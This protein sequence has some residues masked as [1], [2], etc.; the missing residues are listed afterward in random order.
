MRFSF[1][2]IGIHVTTRKEKKGKLL[3]RRQMGV[4]PF[5]QGFDHKVSSINTSL[6]RLCFEVRDTSVRSVRRSN[7]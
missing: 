7:D 3:L 6:V 1:C 5:N 2:K 4:D